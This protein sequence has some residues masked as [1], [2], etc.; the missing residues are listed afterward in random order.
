MKFVFHDTGYR[1]RSNCDTAATRT[2]PRVEE[3]ASL[4]EIKDKF[5]RQ[6]FEWMLKD[7]L[8]VTQTG[9]CVFQIRTE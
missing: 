8:I 4:D 3:Y 6:T 5:L 2:D 1:I 9:S 7:G